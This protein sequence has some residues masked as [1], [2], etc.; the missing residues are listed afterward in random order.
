ML[1][2][3]VMVLP[4]FLLL[5]L[6][7][8]FCD[9]RQ[10]FLTLPSKSHFPPPGTFPHTTSTAEYGLYFCCIDGE[11]AYDGVKVDFHN[12]DSFLEVGGFRLFDDSSVADFGVGRLMPEVLKTK[13]QAHREKSRFQT[14]YSEGER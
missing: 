8:D 9:D 13:V 5:F 10:L 1:I 14:T 12:C 2:H 3:N 4:E 7:F 11:H 6:A